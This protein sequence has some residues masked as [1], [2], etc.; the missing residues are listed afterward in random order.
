MSF[1]YCFSVFVAA[2]RS[3]SL[4]VR[5]G[6]QSLRLSPE[7]EA[8]VHVYLFV[9]WCLRILF[10]S[11]SLPFDNQSPIQPALLLVSVNA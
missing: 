5:W 11:L 6:F 8:C 9:F 10:L 2:G 1:I 4:S 3:P 7:K